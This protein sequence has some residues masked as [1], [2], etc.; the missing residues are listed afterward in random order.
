MRGILDPQAFVRIM[1]MEMA[2]ARRY[3]RPLT[4]VNLRVAGWVQDGDLEL[5]GRVLRGVSEVIRRNLWV[6]DYCTYHGNGRFSLLLPDT[7]RDGAFAVARRLAFRIVGAEDLKGT[8][9]DLEAA[10]ASYP[11][12][13]DTVDE[14]LQELQH[15]PLEFVQGD[16][17]DDDLMS[18]IWRRR[19]DEGGAG[20]EAPESETSVAREPERPEA[21][22]TEVTHTEAVH[23]EPAPEEPVSRE[24]EQPAPA[25]TQSMDA[26]PVHVG[27]EHPEPLHE[28]PVTASP[29]PVDAGPRP[30]ETL[31]YAMPDVPPAEPA[32]AEE[33]EPVE[34]ER[35]SPSGYRHV[36]YH[37]PAR[38]P[39]P[40][41]PVT[42]AWAEERLPIEARPDAPV[43]PDGDAVP[44]EPEWSPAFQVPSFDE[45]D[46]GHV[47]AA[48]DGEPPAPAS[49][50]E[51]P[52]GW[53]RWAWPE[54]RQESPRP[55]P[56][57][58]DGWDGRRDGGAEVNGVAQPV[59]AD[60]DHA[61]VRTPEPATYAEQP[62]A[63]QAPAVTPPVPTAGRA[64][65]VRLP[66][67]ARQWQ[68][69]ADWVQDAIAETEAVLDFIDVAL[70]HS[71]PLLN[72]TPGVEDGDGAAPGAEAGSDSARPHGH[73][74]CEPPSDALR[75]ER[76]A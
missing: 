9:V 38:Y 75:E 44:Q 54:T 14:L 32:P 16:Q 27:L 6:A 17:A 55:E 48:A 67:A 12:H 20:A 5:T 37:E 28:E 63:E 43:P 3:G 4:V 11:E 30:E 33:R 46:H 25:H 62:H 68:A 70:S 8:Q 15:M 29:E 56:W 21:A 57:S 53:S 60:E 18:E 31:G 35:I 49:S 10:A 39:E 52:E 72:R 74:V 51:A 66:G 45:V 36:A 19:V 34:S 76:S 26:E 73:H 7:G 64:R 42:H 22:D 1:E 47:A 23:E 58:W 41:L 71:R 61:P 24:A 2:R 59:A 40:E 69:A 13:G 65:P 50:G